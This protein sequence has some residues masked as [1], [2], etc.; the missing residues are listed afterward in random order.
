MNTV[1]FGSLNY[2]VLTIYLVGMLG[3]GIYFSRKQENAEMF[4]LGGRK[5][6]WIAVAMSM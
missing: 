4:F 6:P 2:C 3:I 5:L 1:H